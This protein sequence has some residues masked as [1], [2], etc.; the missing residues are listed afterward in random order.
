[1]RGCGSRLQ[2][3]AGEVVV[4]PSLVE[5]PEK[6]LRR[7]Y[8]VELND[9]GRVKEVRSKLLRGLRRIDGCVLPGKLK[10]WCLKFGLM[11]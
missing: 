7:W 10:A 2:V 3:L 9:V 4:V 1:M 6:S 11:P 8:M 5:A